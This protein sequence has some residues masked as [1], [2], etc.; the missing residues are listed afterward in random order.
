VALLQ[1]ETIEKGT[2]QQRTVGYVAFPFFLDA[3]TGEMPALQG[4]KGYRLR[5]AG[6][7]L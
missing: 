7:L 5:E 3:E 2:S 1:I 4:A 6:R